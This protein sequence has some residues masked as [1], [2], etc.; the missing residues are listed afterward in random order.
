MSFE[1]LMNLLFYGSGP[2]YLAMFML[3]IAAFS[4]FFGLF[5]LSD[6]LGRLAGWVIRADWSAPKI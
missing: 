3:S 1:V 5:D 4:I 6:C 2:G